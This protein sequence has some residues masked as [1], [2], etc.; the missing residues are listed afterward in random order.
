[1]YNNGK[2][3]KKVSYC[4]LIVKNIKISYNKKVLTNIV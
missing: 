1:V 3:V 4:K 2:M